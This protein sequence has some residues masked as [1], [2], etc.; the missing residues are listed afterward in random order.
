[1]T[2]SRTNPKVDD[3]LNRA[4][5][6]RAEFEQLRRIALGSGM[7]EDLKWGVPAYTHDGNNVIL[8]QGFKEYCAILFVKGALLQDNERILIQQTQKVQAARQIR[9]TNVEEIKRSEKVVR[10]YL[11][12]AVELEKAG[13]KVEFK[14]SEEYAVP[15]ELQSRLDGDAALA[16]A[17]AALTP[18]RQRAYLQHFTE[19]KQSKTREA[20]IDKHTPRIMEGK[21]LNDR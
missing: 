12:E 1:M 13:M 4:E 3:F 17:F 19:P 6:W 2:E 15:Q 7:N 16:E 5:K 21:G 11:A 20:R 8:L 9:F 18:G 10:E 14:P